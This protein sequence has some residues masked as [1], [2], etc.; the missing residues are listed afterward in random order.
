MTYG[1]DAI[2]LV[3]ENP[4]RLAREIHGIGFKTADAIAQKL[5]SEKTSML[6]ARA[7]I[8]YALLEAIGDGHC[9]LPE[10]ELLPKA[11]ALLEI[12]LEPLVEAL[13]LEVADGYVTSGDIGGK[14]CAFLPHLWL[15]EQV[16]AERLQVL[17]T[18]PPPWSV[19]APEEPR[20]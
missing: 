14:P 13:A 4:Y 6:R 20:P 11:V 17:A 1:A 10:D 15:A 2:P 18:G 19:L 16:V 5:G 8:T 12:P 9:A 7:G 3:T